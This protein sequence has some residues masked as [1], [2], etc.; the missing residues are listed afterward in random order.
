MSVTSRGES[1][2]LKMGQDISPEQRKEIC[3]LLARG[4]YL[5]ALGNVLTA[6]EPESKE[7]LANEI[8]R[9]F[10]GEL[11]VCNTLL[12]H[13]LNSIQ[14]PPITNSQYLEP[15]VKQLYAV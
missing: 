9:L 14:V 8:T 5:D 1:F 13:A 6:A 7:H 15:L 12:L 11:L 10:S 3:Q 4:G 2:M